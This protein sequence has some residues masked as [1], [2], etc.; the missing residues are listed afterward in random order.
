VRDKGSSNFCDYFEFK[1][2]GPENKSAFEIKKK[3]AR[4]TFDKLFGG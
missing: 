2:G 1:K 4:D 3:T